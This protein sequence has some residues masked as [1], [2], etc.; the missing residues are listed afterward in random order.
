[1]PFMNKKIALFGEYLLRLTPPQQQKLV[2]SHS[3]EMHW[4]GSEA[5]IAV[6]LSIFGT[7]SL[8]ITALPDN[9][10]ARAGLSRLHQYAVQTQIVKT[11][12]ARVGTYYYESGQGARPGRVIYD[13]GIFLIQLPEARSNKLER[14]SEHSGLVPLERYYTRFKPGNGRYMQRSIRGCATKKTG[15]FSR[16]QLSQYALA[17]WKALQPGN[18]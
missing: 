10:L 12:G 8:Y 11:E 2:Q 1:M 18:A 17:I 6:S 9:E 7:P 3:L 15:N 4:A 16:F 5:N 13:R 14:N